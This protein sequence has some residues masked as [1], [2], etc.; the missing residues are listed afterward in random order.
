MHT[1]TPQGDPMKRFLLITLLFSIIV[2]LVPAQSQST[3]T[4]YY[5]R[6]SFLFTSPGAMKFGLYGTD[7]PALLATIR[8]PDILITWNDANDPMH[9]WG[10]FAGVPYAGLGM[11]RVKIEGAAV[12]NYHLSFASGDRS[13]ST[14]ISYGW[15]IAGNPALDKSSL[16]TLGSLFRPI[17]LLST[18]ITYTSALNSKGYELAGDIAGRPFGT[19]LLTI[20][21]DYILHRTPQLDQDTWSAGFALE[22]LPGIRFTA[23]YF[24]SEAFTF[25]LQFNLGRIGLE[26]QTR[27]AVNQRR[28]MT[29]YGIRIGAYDRNIFDQA[30]VAKKVFVELNR[31]MHV[32]YQRYL[33]FDNTQTLSSLIDLIDAAKNDAA[34]AGIAINTS[35]LSADAEKLWELREKLKDLKASGKK[36]FIFI[37]RGDI[38]LYHFASVADKIVMDPM[39]TVM[40][41]G[42]VMG[43]TFL[44]GTL[45]KI[46]L[47]FDEWRF[48]K[49]KSANES[50]SRENM[51]DADRE[52]R[53]KLVDDWYKIVS[54]E[55]SE[56][57]HLTSDQIDTLVNNKVLFFAQQ[58][59]EMGLIDS[60]GRWEVVKDLVRQTTGHDDSFIS[61]R[62]IAKFN[63]PYDN[64]W[65]EPPQIA[66]IYAL[67]VCD[68]DRGIAARRLVKDFEAA[69][70]NSKIKAIVLRIDSPGGDGMASDYIAEAVKK[71]KGRKPIIVSQGFVAASGGYWLSMYAD[72]IVA[73]PRTIT[74][75]IGVIGGWM[76]NQGLK[77]KLGLST[78]F[79]KVG[80]H[81]DL[82]FGMTLPLIGMQIPDR[83]LT[84]G[85]R[86]VAEAAIKNMYK[87]FVEKV[88]L[89]RRK[90]ASDIEPIA[91]GRVWSGLDGKQ[92]GLVDVL[93]GLETAIDIAKN[94]AGIPKYQE[95]SIIEMPKKGLFDFSMFMPKLF[96]V[97]TRITSDPTVELLKFRLQHNGKPLP[98]LP[99]EDIEPRTM[100]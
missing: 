17:P 3:I 86:A 24:N 69:A 45:E 42:F 81:A 52:Q 25:G 54:D 95:C 90:P 50:L 30:V 93:G 7:N 65:G 58:A 55:I 6:N 16:L 73:A 77:E 49:Y 29:S 62:S 67:G 89:G 26:S 88:S 23:R 75:S 79:V 27:S 10:M 57:R 43:R 64:R 68:M 56:S 99:M 96:G 19:E 34:V 76:Y 72:T 51:S 21:A 78:D 61:P 8:Q 14:G 2:D 66:V 9:R 28:T 83:N 74:G 11:E 36:V 37:D 13:F 91:Q 31:P 59:K 39:G 85:E 63:L 1:G 4:P 32:D 47:G 5:E 33:F 18:G 60:I 92:N 40:L 97:E 41:D 46:G 80:A 48:F 53:Q 94:R 35:G 15:T 20:F 98:M 82:G 22:A 84:A 87:E 100:E 12:S 71:A 44:K 70:D 38:N